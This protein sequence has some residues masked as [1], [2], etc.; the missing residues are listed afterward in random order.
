MKKLLIPLLAVIAGLT[1]GLFILMGDTENL[2]ANLDSEWD[3]LATYQLI[4]DRQALTIE[5]YQNKLKDYPGEIE[6]YAQQL[7]EYAQRDKLLEQMDRTG[8]IE[9]ASTAEALEWVE[10]RKECNQ[11]ITPRYTTYAIITEMGIVYSL[12][13]NSDELR[14]F[15]YVQ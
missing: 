13:P 2:K 1:G 14:F 6:E 10:L 7:D 9:F 12:S 4:V 3:N 8:W 5:D 15:R 11:N